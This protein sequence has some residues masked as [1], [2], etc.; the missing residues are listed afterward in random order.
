MTIP[1]K[2]TCVDCGDDYAGLDQRYRCDCG[3][4]LDVI[5]DLDALRG[6]LSLQTFDDRV[7][8]GAPPEDRS[9]VWRFRELVLP[10]AP[11]EIVAKPE[12][13]T[14]LYHALPLYRNRG[15][16]ET[17]LF[18]LNAPHLNTPTPTHTPK[19]VRGGFTATLAEAI[20]TGSTHAA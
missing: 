11:E 17:Q 10:L 4:T 1:W 5:Q 3:G 9:G 20:Y 7:R 8:P 12:G 2:L 18:Y 19:H 16:H 15:P 6:T 14:N 13:N